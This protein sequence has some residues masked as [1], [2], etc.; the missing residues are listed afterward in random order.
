MFHRDT[1]F[2]ARLVNG[3]LDEQRGRD[4]LV[5][6]SPIFQ[7]VA[8]RLLAA[9]AEEHQPIWDDFLAGRLR[10]DPVS[11]AALETHE[12]PPPAVVP[13]VSNPPGPLQPSPT[14]P[15][16][17]DA[18]PEPRVRLTC[19]VD[20]E[21]RNVDWLWPGRVPLGM[22]TMF[23]GD[24][25]LGKSFVTLAMAAAV[26]R[27]LPLP[28]GDLP[29]QPGSTI[30]MSAEDDPARTIVRRLI[31]AGADLNKIHVLESVFLANGSEALPSLR[32]D[33]DAITAAASRLGD[34][35]LIVVD[36]VSAYLK[37]VDDNRNA[38]LRGVL[39]PLKRSPSGWVPRSYSSAI[40]PKRL[41]QQQ[42][43]GVLGSI[44]YVGACRANHLFV[45]DPHDPTGRRVLMLDNGGNVAPAAPTLAYVIDDCGS[46]PKVVWADNPVAITI[47]QASDP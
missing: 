23:A 4:D 24:P 11:E 3:S 19:A 20:L 16:E 8:A 27:G 1:F 31:T 40:S 28:M 36:P 33:I 13:E 32:A 45:A 10:S 37:G 15:E 46:G 18:E 6:L 21:P 47:E 44:A 26:S 42:A 35:R 30:L 39:T 43:P 22:I 41:G 12:P 34:C 29:N 38:A 2:L 5:R 14:S 25:K 7:P 17:G 9:P